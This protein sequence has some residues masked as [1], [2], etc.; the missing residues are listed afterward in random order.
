MH[1]RV[2]AACVACGDVGLCH[3]DG[4][5]VFVVDVGYFV[6]AALGEGIDPGIVPVAWVGSFV[7]ESLETLDC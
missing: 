6:D 3:L 4:C 1:F 2:V 5:G 7:G